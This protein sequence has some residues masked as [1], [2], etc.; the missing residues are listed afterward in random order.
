MKT[1]RP[2]FVCSLTKTERL[3]GAF[4]LPVHMFLLPVLLSMLLEY[5]PTG[6][7]AVQRNTLYFAITFVLILLL[8]RSF[9]RKEW[10]KLCDYKLPCL[11]IIVPAHLLCVLLSFVVVGLT[12]LLP[13]ELSALYDQALMELSG[14]SGEGSFTLLVLLVPIV[15]ETL[16]R[17]LVFGSLRE[18]NRLA[19]YL[20]SVLLYVLC[21]VWQY[22]VRYPNASILF[23]ALQ[24]IPMAFALAWCYER[25]GSIWSPILYHAAYNLI[26]S[27][28][29]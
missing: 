10:D 21:A 29:S 27:L 20:V 19:A 22:A 23:Y 12:L 25:S 9:L 1:Q 28:M 17:G 14:L 8:M 7:S 5:W 24:E 2:P 11:L 18:K 26:P 15:E 4:L 16:F 3:L 6:F 13:E